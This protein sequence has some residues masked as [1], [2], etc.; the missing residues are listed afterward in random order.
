[1]FTDKQQVMASRGAAIGERGVVVSGNIAGIA[2][3]P[4]AAASGLNLQV[5]TQSLGTQVVEGV[6]A[7]G[8]RT[9][10]TIPAGAIGNELPIEMVAER[11]YSPELQ[12]VV[13]TRRTDPRFGETVYRLT[14]IVRAEPPAALFQI[15]SDFKIEEGKRAFPAPRPKPDGQ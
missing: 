1:V 11:W 6:R 15:P 8:T 3:K 7:E 5:D 13:L 2:A 10:T 14:N 12:V 9:T 4:Y